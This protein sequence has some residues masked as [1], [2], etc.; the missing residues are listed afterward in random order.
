METRK[1]QL[2]HTNTLRAYFTLTTI[3]LILF[4][5][6]LLASYFHPITDTQTHS[7]KDMMGWVSKYWTHAILNSRTL[8]PR[9]SRHRLYKT[10]AVKRCKNPW[11]LL[12]TLKNG[13]MRFCFFCFVSCLVFPR[14]KGKVLHTARFTFC[15]TERRRDLNA[16]LELLKW[17]NWCVFL[18]FSCVKRIGKL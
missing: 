2:T 10:T 4:P 15:I 5:L 7:L 12:V 17:V 3:F 1:E 16:S 11:L 18:L 8:H 13:S 14:S 9:Y 6:H